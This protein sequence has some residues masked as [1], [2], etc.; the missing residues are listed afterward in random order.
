MAAVNAWPGRA[1]PAWEDVLGRA[2]GALESDLGTAERHALLFQMGRWYAER[3]MRPDLAL[4]WLTQLVAAE[5]NHD[6][7]LLQL[8]SIYK[9]AQQWAE[10]GQVLLRRADVAAPNLARDLRVEAA[11]VL[12]AAPE[13][14]GPLRVSCTSRCWRK[15]RG[16]KRPAQA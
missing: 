14:P 4:P 7:A 3:V 6:P 15:I 9:K 10:Y 16:T 2:I 1:T 11:E 12:A 13:Q 8:S 5:P